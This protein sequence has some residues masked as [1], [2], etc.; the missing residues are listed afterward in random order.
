MRKLHNVQFDVKKTELI[1]FDN[2]K[3]VNEIFSQIHE[4]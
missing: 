3:K 2:S 4:K 1:H